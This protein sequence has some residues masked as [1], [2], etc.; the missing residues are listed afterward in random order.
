[1]KKVRFLALW[2]SLF[3]CTVVSAQHFR[4]VGVADGLPNSVVKCFAQDEKGYLWMGTFNGLCRY[5]GFGFATYRNVSGDSTSIAN[6]HVEALLAQE[7]GLYVGTTK[8]LDW[9]SFANGQFSRCT[10]INEEGTAQTL[11]S[12][13]TQIEQIDDAIFVLDISR[14]L[15]VKQKGTISFNEFRVFAPSQIYAIAPYRDNKMLL[16]TSEALMLVDTKSFQVIDRFPVKGLPLSWNNLYYSKN[17]N[18]AVLGSSIGYAGQTFE[19]SPEN[20]ISIAKLRVPEN[21]KATIDYNNKTYF[22]TDGEGLFEYSREDNLIKCYTPQ[23]S[24]ISGF[25]VHSLFADRGGN[26]WIGTYRDGLNVLSSRFDFF[27]CYTMAAGELSYQVV[28]S[29]YVNNG[30]IYAGMD[31]GGLNIIDTHSGKTNVLNTT[32]SKLPG[33]NVLTMTGD[34]NYLWMGIYNKGLCR[35]NL[36]DGTIKTYNLTEM[37]CPMKLDALWQI[38]DD[39]QGHIVV[40]GDRTCAIEKLT[41]KIVWS[42]NSTIKDC[43]EVKQAKAIDEL[44]NHEIECAL[45]DEA[46]NL[47]IGTDNGLFCQVKET[48]ALL[49][50]GKEDNLTLNQFCK[51]SCFR[52]GKTLY[53]GSTLGLVCFEPAALLAYSQT[54]EVHIDALSVLK[55]NRL[56]S[57]TSKSKKEITLKH[58]QNFFTIHISVP[59]LIVPGKVRFRYMLKG[60]DSDWRELEG[61]REVAYTNV[62]PG[63]YTF[64]I[65]TRDSAGQWNEHC[66]EL[67]LNIS[68]PWYLTWWAKGLWLLLILAGVFALFGFYLHEQSVKQKLHQKE[69]EKEMERKINEEKMNFFANITHELRTPMFL[70]TAPLEELLDSKKRPVSVPYSYLNGMYRNAVRLNNLVNRILDIRKLDIGSLKMKA[71]RCDIVNLCRRLSVDYT[72]LCRQKNLSYRF[73][74]ERESFAVSIDVEKVELILSNLVSNA[75]KYTDEG[76][77]V[78]LLLNAKDDGSIVLSVSDTGAGISTEDIPHIFDS[79]YRVEKTSSAVGDGIGLAF[80][81][82]LVEV[83]GG[84]IDV[85]SELGKGSIF[86]VVLPVQVEEAEQQNDGEQ[87]ANIDNLMNVIEDTASSETP[88]ALPNPTAARSILIIDDERETVA[89]LERYLGKNYKIVKA[90]DGEEGLKMVSAQLPDLIICDVMMPRM[91]GFEFLNRI[92][93]DKKLQ[94]I[95]VIMFSAK[96]LDEDKI[97]AFKYGADAYLTKPVSLKMLLTRVEQFMGRNEAT[98][99]ASM[100]ELFHTPSNEENP[101][102]EKSEASTKEDERFLLRCRE[103]IDANLCNNQLS[104]DFLANELNMSHSGLYKKV[105]AITD[106]SVVDLIVD[107]RIFRAVEKFK[108]GETN[109][110]FVSEQFGFNDIR[111]FRAAFKSRMGISPKQFVQQLG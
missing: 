86:T 6:S 59:E 92:K 32:N 35:Y 18:V 10:Y 49:P 7:E 103:I 105:K 4:A 93:E 21:I 91:D 50:F 96:I 27:K 89:L 102:I 41:V 81:K 75:Y 24:L 66:S 57:F 15:W 55:D 82:Q 94:H 11:S 88:S 9:F 30:K 80:V 64:S 104:V 23:N 83:C 28:S 60:I 37:G 33:N 76:G 44:K 47:W 107:Y 68:P 34:S 73:V 95:P 84:K 5:D 16:L 48:G 46:G 3:L 22:A 43:D 87:A 78:T 72:A 79:F 110:T 14:R 39:G 2:L 63:D 101:I 1:M 65:C 38:T 67:T 26:L 42:N 53:F 99:Y 97:T 12:Y 31:G 70:I 111:S 45:R 71:T 25:A 52:Q 106:R 77:N 20:R 17:L 58:N 100:K 69:M 90:Y 8:G 13:I 36:S 29:L 85:K 40:T 61:K 19:I 51:N 62:P 56:Y 54:D 74:C 109:I 98:L 108:S